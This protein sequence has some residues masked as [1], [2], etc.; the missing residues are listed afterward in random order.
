MKKRNFAKEYL[1]YVL[2]FAFGLVF[3][4]KP[5]SDMDEIWNFGFV[6]YITT[7]LRPYED[8]NIIQTPLSAYIASVFLS[9]FGNN[10]LVFRILSAVLFSLTFG[11]LYSICYKIID[12]KPMAFAV[13]SFACA[14]CS[15]IWMYNYNHLVLLVILVVIFCE[16][17]S[18]NQEESAAHNLYVI[19]GL[20]FGLTPIIKQST[21]FVLILYNTV[22]CLYKFTKKSAKR[23]YYAS[24][25]ITSLV[26]TVLFVLHLIVI[27]T[28]EEFYDY[29]VR[30]IQ[31]FSHRESWFN[32]ILSNPI[33]FV[34]GIF[35]IC[36]TALSVYTICKG[37]SKVSKSFHVKV[38]L[39]CWAGRVV[40]Y[41]ICDF[42]HAC[43][44]VVPFIIP[45]ICC[46]NKL[47]LSRRDAL[48]CYLV[49]VM[50][51]C[52]SS[53]LIIKELPN[54]KQCS[55]DHF[56]RLPISPNLEKQIQTVNTYIMDEGKNGVNVIIADE[57]AAAYMIP[58]DRYYK[59]FN[60]LLV[61]NIGSNSIHDLLWRENAIYLVA[62]SETTMGK[63]AHR[64]LVEYIKKNYIKIGE[65]S[66]FDA[67]A[68]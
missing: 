54:Y 36:V 15:Q 67:Y 60:L 53:G 58:I 26:P 68:P 13:A 7:G 37:K 40:A 17:Q 4:A 42:V 24:R 63:Q 27:G 16:H 38:L 48:A 8:F 66:G 29:A 59:N 31:T 5:I 6:S 52:C 41:P 57:D 19:I 18:E 50:V 43:V 2:F 11:I 28:F 9:L 3:L 30:G 46:I 32:Y 44:A 49:A 25:L 55:L 62:K 34:V 39:L 22:F 47:Y 1:P 65:V 20:L 56:E 35:P 64:E 21:G 14:F 33:D 45:L 23:R 61:G 12:S 51:L 10:L